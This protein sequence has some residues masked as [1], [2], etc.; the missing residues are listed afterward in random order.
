MI[1]S[2]H[3]LEQALGIRWYGTDTPGIGG[4]LRKEPEDFVVEE[5]PAPV[6]GQG[7]HLLCRLTKRNWELQRAVREIARALGISHRRISWAGTKD[8]RAVTTQLLSIRGVEPEELER[9]ALG[10]LRIE[11]VGRSERPLRLGMLE[12]NRF[13]IRI[14]ECE[15]ERLEERVSEVAQSAKQGLPNYFGIQRFGTLRPVT[16]LVGEKILQGYLEG[17]VKLYIGWTCGEEPQEALA[18]RRDFMETGNV[19]AALRNFPATL[20][21]ERAL[22]Q[23]LHNRHGDYRGAL[24]SLPPKLLSMFVSAYQ[25]CL[26]NLALSERWEDGLP[27]LEPRPGD[28]LLFENGRIDRVTRENLPSALLHCRRGRALPALYIPGRDRERGKEVPEIVRRVMEGRGIDAGS[29]ARASE[30]VGLVFEGF[31]RPVA[32]FTEIDARVE[33]DTVG[34]DFRLGPG[35]YATT[36]CREFMKADPRFMI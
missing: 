31:Q 26:F 19:S 29:F 16:H 23:H 8:R 36:V 2:P 12:G 22:L 7:P 15:R 24:R 9:V 5:L 14:R 13:R 34:L 21:Y 6:G 10:D 1:R 27:L 28:L 20:S 17:A 3:T 35:Q 18:A 33:E 4:V 25:S 11:P 30:L 32:L